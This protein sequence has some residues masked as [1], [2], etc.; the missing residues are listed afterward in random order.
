MSRGGTSPWPRCRRWRR[1]RRRGGEGGAGTVSL[2]DG[3]ALWH[4]AHVHVPGIAW[5][6]ERYTLH[7]DD[8]VIELEFPSPYLNHHQTSLVVR[9]SQGRRLETLHV[10][11]GYEEAFVREL[12]ASLV[13]LDAGYAA[14]QAVAAGVLPGSIGLAVPLEAMGYGDVSR[15]EVTAL[16]EGWSA[17]KAR[18]L[19]AAAAKLLL[20]Y[21]VDVPSQAER[22]EAVV[23]AVVADC[24]AAG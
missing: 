15:L 4:L 13:R 2:L 7:F 18:R 6:R 10:A 21:R 8:L 23:R 24:R 11:A 9:R 22:Q 3:R 17:A 16:L 14:A 1:C 12:E 20:P 19:G 5:Y